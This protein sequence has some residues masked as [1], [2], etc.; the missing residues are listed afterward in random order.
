MFKYQNGAPTNEDWGEQVQQHYHDSHPQEFTPPSQPLH[1]RGESF[2]YQTRQTSPPQQPQPEQYGEPRYRKKE[3]TSGPSDPRRDT[4]VGD[5]RL[6][7]LDEKHFFAGLKTI[8]SINEVSD[9]RR[10]EEDLVKSKL[11][12]SGFNEH[13]E[14]QDYVFGRTVAVVGYGAKMTGRVGTLTNLVLAFK[15]YGEELGEIDYVSR[16][17]K[18][19]KK[20]PADVVDSNAASSSSSSSSSSETPP[21]NGIPGLEENDF[22]PAKK[23]RRHRRKQKDKAPD[24]EPEKKTDGRTFR[25]LAAAPPKTIK[26][27]VMDEEEN[28]F[29][30]QRTSRGS[31]H[32][33]TSRRK[34]PAN[35]KTDPKLGMNA[36]TI[37]YSTNE[38]ATVTIVHIDWS[39]INSSSALHVEVASIL[40]ELFACKCTTKILYEGTSLLDNLVN[41]EGFEVH[42]VMDVQRMHNDIVGD[43]NKHAMPSL[44]VLHK[45]YGIPKYLLG[46]IAAH[47]G[48]ASLM[49]YLQTPI[50]KLGNKRPGQRIEEIPSAH[51][52][53]PDNS[54][55]ASQMDRMGCD[56]W[57]IISLFDKMMSH[58]ELGQ[59]HGQT[60][61][62]RT[63]Y[64]NFRE[65]VT[66]T[67]EWELLCPEEHEIGYIVGSK[68]KNIE[69]IR[70]ISGAAVELYQNSRILVSACTANQV[71][72]AKQLIWYAVKHHGD[73]KGKNKSR[74]YTN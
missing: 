13:P 69:E 60:L 70:Q 48:F 63:D 55:N 35:E 66:N 18:P 32:K 46:P 1:P 64:V 34:H 6:N 51:P 50:V 22:I 52:W 3:Y 44:G 62:M 26:P 45:R 47:H 42:N 2:F 36:N 12:G 16:I 43:E 49:S 15:T 74:Q 33:P 68:G 24:A 21:S 27:K 5:L 9:A 11:F 59:D 8:Y 28:P 65:T 37:F 20:S 25:E 39:L 4:G 29:L 54:C 58:V 61:R 40:G 53:A 10:L 71:Q 30:T 38:H 73:I 56:A 19:P 14:K 72:Q 31:Q 57:T 67:T 7:R 17:N 23:R 41:K